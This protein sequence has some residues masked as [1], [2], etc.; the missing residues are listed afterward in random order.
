M[1]VQPI[2]V[3]DRTE[4]FRGLFEAH[5]GPL[6][7]YARRRTVEAEVDDVV[8]ETFSIAWRRL[9]AIPVHAELPWL[10]G[11]A[12][13][14]LANQRRSAK[15][16]HRLHARLYAEPALQPDRSSPDDSVRDALATLRPDDRE[17]LRLAA[18]EELSTNEIAVVL[19]CTPNAAALRLS[20]ARRRLRVELTERRDRRTPTARKDRD[21]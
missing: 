6:I 21:A 10:Y 1:Y 4:R 13:R 17:I 18:W 19:D 15:R 3:D 8:A 11:V 16:R 7:A 9:E 20:R 5:Y 12:R 2:G 14:V